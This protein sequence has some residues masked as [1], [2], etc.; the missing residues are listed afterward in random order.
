MW[1]QV[2]LFP[3][4]IA[5]S[6]LGVGHPEFKLALRELGI[7]KWPY[8]TVDALTKLQ[9]FVDGESYLNPDLVQKRVS[10]KHARPLG[11]FMLHNSKVRVQNEPYTVFVQTPLVELHPFVHTLHSCFALLHLHFFFSIHS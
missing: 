1:P 8:R 10:Q 4:G 11:Q 2:L 9:T 3:G 5:A 6:F 7:L